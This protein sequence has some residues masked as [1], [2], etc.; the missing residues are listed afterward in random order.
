MEIYCFSCKKNTENENY[1]VRKTKQNKLM[2]LLSSAIYG[3][4]KSTSIKKFRRSQNLLLV[5]L[6]HLINIAKEFKI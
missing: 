4:E 1:S 5:L 6:D 2:P 3:K